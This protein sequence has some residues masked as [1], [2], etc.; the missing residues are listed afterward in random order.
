MRKLTLTLLLF[1]TSTV[2]AQ[3]PLTRGARQWG[4]WAAYSPASLH[5]IGKTDRKVFTLN[6]QYARVLAA[7]DWGA[8]KGTTEILPVA[9]ARDSEASHTTYGGGVTPVGLQFNFGKRRWQPF[10][11]GNAGLLYFTEQV[12]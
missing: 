8:V 7:P 11:A 2:V 1:V 4:A 3:E 6:L 10:F 5:L 9:L 12:P